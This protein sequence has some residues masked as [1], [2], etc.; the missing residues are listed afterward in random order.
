MAELEGR[1]I[2]T[3]RVV[4][5]PSAP[6]GQLLSEA[7]SDDGLVKLLIDFPAGPVEAVSIPSGKRT[8]YC[9]SCQTGCAL[10][11]SFCATAR[12]GPGKNLSAA[13]MQIQVRMLEKISGTPPDNLVFMGMG[14][15]MHNLDEV[16]RA[17]EL[18]E[19]EKRISPKRITVSTV[20][21]V[22]GIAELARR[23][24]ASLALSL[25]SADDKTRSEIMP[26]NRSYPLGKLKKALLD[27]CEVR[28]SST[29]VYIEYLMLSGVNDSLKDAEKLADFLEGIPSKVNLMSYNQGGARDFKTSPDERITEFRE[30]LKEKGKLSFFRRSRGS[31]IGAA[32]GQLTARPK[33][34]CSEA[35]L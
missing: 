15:P 2:P 11:C 8:T 21:L 28:G 33:E 23:S 12:L 26:V 32:C 3:A 16:I 1:Y 27:F 7:R 24:R 10:G 30:R 34:S 22:P 6:Q 4:R 35:V 18:F 19:K 9:L 14:E 20:G 13:E 17:A 5:S 29:W 25:H 31:D